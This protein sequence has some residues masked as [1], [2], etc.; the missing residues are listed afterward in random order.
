MEKVILMLI[1]LACNTIVAEAQTEAECFQYIKKLDVPSEVMALPNDNPANFW[2]YL[3]KYNTEYQKFE[4]ALKKGKNTA[5]SA[6]N[7]IKND[8]M[9]RTDFQK[10]LTDE[11][12]VEV[13]DSVYKFFN[14]KVYNPQMKV[15]IVGDREVNA[16]STPDAI[17]LLNSGLLNKMG[18]FEKIYAVVG[19]ELAHYALGH[20]LQNLYAVKKKEKRNQII[21]G[22][23]SGIQ[24]AGTAIGQAMYSDSSP[25]GQKA[26][27]QAWQDVR[28]GLDK[29][30]EWA[31]ID[32][33]GRYHLKYSR[34][35]EMEADIASYRFLQW[36]GEDPNYMIKMLEI[37]GEGEPKI[38]Q[39]NSAHPSTSF[40]INVLKAIAKYDEVKNANIIKK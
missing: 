20:V 16:Y 28:N 5:Q 8:L 7:E 3:P 37:L 40:R 15:Y 31:T 30:L 29:N 38:D 2:W 24:A 21:A 18:T 4:T 11:N 1:V 17:I 25:S 33:Y 26:R 36:I 14:L 12:S 13:L 9:F 32:A 23:A 10:G 6:V 34:I 35:Q 39:K 27:E 19:H 22:V